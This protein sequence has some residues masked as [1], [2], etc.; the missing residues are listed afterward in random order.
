M[1]RKLQIQVFSLYVT[2]P[3][4]G[5]SPQSEAGMSAIL[6]TRENLSIGDEA[7]FKCHRE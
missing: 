7:T 1:K 3:D 4:G 2:A 6:D 5:F